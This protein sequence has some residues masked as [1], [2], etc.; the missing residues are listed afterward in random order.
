MHSSATEMVRYNRCSLY[1][2][3]AAEPAETAD[4]SDGCD[5]VCDSTIA[6]PAKVPDDAA[7]LL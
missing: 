6:D 4:S 2:Q 1:F 7:G 5:H 3:H